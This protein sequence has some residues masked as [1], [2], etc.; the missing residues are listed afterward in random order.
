MRYHLFLCSWIPAG[1]QQPGALPAR[2]NDMAAPGHLAASSRCV[3]TDWIEVQS[4]PGYAEVHMAGGIPQPLH[5]PA[6]W[7][8]QR[9]LLCHCRGALLRRGPLNYVPVPQ[10][11]HPISTR[12]FALGSPER[13]HAWHARVCRSRH[14]PL[15]NAPSPPAVQAAWLE[16]LYNDCLCQL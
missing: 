15:W 4:S 7:C 10:L 13:V 8:L 11:K 6:L 14:H 3:S 5:G 2:P 12:P 16:T 9:L 1:A